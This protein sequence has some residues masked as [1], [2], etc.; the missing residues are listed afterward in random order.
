MRATSKTLFRTTSVIQFA[1]GL[2]ACGGP[3]EPV[4][5]EQYVT[6]NDAAPSTPQRLTKSFTLQPPDVSDRN[7]AFDK[8][9]D[10]PPKALTSDFA[11]TLQVQYPHNSSH[12]PG[13]INVVGTLDC[14]S[15]TYALALNVDLY[16]NGVLVASSPSKSGT[17]TSHLETNAATP[18]VPGAYYGIAT[19]SVLAGPFYWPPL[20]N[21]WVLSPTRYLTC[22]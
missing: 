18:C 22:D 8:L 4:T 15:W 3:I 2:A 5:D 10:S 11:C 7:A 13:T 19:G 9:T 21:A 14:S 1:I 6:E 17:F 16:R 20:W 12:F